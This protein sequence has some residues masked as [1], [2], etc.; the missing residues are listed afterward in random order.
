MNNYYRLDFQDLE[1]WKLKE[2]PST[3]EKYY[4]KVKE[5]GSFFLRE[6]S[7]ILYNGMICNYKEATI[8]EGIRLNNNDGLIIIEPSN[9]KIPEKAMRR[10]SSTDEIKQTDSIIFRNISVDTFI[11]NYISDFTRGGRNR[12][13]EDEVELLRKKL[14]N[15][16]VIVYNDSILS[17]VSLLFLFCSFIYEKGIIS[18]NR[19][20][21]MDCIFSNQDNPEFKSILE[22]TKVYGHEHYDVSSD[23]EYAIACLKYVGI[24]HPNYE[25]DQPYEYLSIDIWVVFF[26]SLYNKMKCQYP[27]IDQLFN[28]FIKPLKHLEKKDI[29]FKV[30]SFLK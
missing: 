21:L 10:L 11:C 28:T 27:E 15:D 7:S 4:E 13:S 17:S 30:K 1:F 8:Y 12:I 9:I 20:E 16:S 22:N 25:K 3:N 6:T 26:A 14:I 2:N 19:S 23:L 24:I 5:S 18:F 29:I